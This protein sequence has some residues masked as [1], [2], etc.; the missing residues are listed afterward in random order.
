[1][2]IHVA[3]PLPRLEPLTYEVPEGIDVRRGCRVLVPLGTRVLTGTVVALDQ[4]PVEKMRPILEV[5][6]EEP[7]FSEQMLELT[8]RISEYYFTS[9]GEVLHAALPTGLTPTTVVR[10]TVMSPVTEQ[11]LSLD[12][13]DS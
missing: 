5:L 12:S 9:W 10:V 1:M 3:L 8:K 6:D 11:D 2:P 4:P 7:S 13:N